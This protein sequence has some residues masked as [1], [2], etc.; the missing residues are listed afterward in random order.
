[1]INPVVVYL[2]CFLLKKWIK[3]RAKLF[4][5]DFEFDL[6]LHLNTDHQ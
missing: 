2:Q 5:F 3:V 6:A 1:M 4:S